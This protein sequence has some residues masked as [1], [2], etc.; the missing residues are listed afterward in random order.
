[1]AQ[2][3]YVSSTWCT[4][5]D[6]GASGTRTFE[7]PGTELLAVGHTHVC[8]SDRSTRVWCAGFGVDREELT[9]PSAVDALVAVG[10]AT[11]ALLDTGELHCWGF[12]PVLT[13]RLFGAESTVPTQVPGVDAAVAVGLGRSF[14]CLLHSDGSVSR[15]TGC[16]SP[17]GHGSGFTTVS[18]VSGAQ[19]LAVG[20]DHAC[21][22]TADD[23]VCWGANWQAEPAECAG[24][25]SVRVAA[26]ALE[27]RGSHTCAREG[28]RMECWGRNWHQQ[29]GGPSERPDLGR[30]SFTLP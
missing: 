4:N 17:P 24:P 7:E 22:Q 26:D 15:T 23:V 9:L 11:C 16:W 10:G 6:R 18:G 14:L 13:G 25:A 28:Q 8:G 30:V 19:Q 12:H 2:G 29:L 20:A 27:V 5:S 3:A 21:V 1:M